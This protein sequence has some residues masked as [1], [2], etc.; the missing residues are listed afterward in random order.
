MREYT[1]KVRERAKGFDSSSKRYPG[2]ICW[3][4]PETGDGER[5]DPSH[6]HSMGEVNFSV[7]CAGG[8]FDC[9]RF[10]TATILDFVTTKRC[11][12]I[13]TGALDVLSLF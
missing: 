12:V 3:E 4:R 10:F 5:A 9:R 8:Y 11:E 13:T 6:H 7:G 1:G 2:K